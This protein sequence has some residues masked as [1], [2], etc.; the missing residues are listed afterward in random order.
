MKVLVTG[1]NGYIGS[2]L[3]DYLLAKRDEAAPPTYEVR[4]MV[5]PG[6]PL[7]NLSSALGAPNFELVEGD[8]L[9]PATL[10]R[11]VSGV[12][13]VFHLAAL[14][15][16][17][18]PKRKFLEV[19]RDGTRHLLE[20]ATAAGVRRFVYMSTLAVHRRKGH[21]GG[22][23]NTPRDEKKNPYA[24]AKHLAEDLLAEAWKA[25]S[26]ETV[27]VRPGWVI[28]GPRDLLSFGQLARALEDGRMAFINGGNKL[29]SHVYVGNL[30][31]ALEH[32]ASS[33]AEK[34]AGQ[35]F[36]AA[37]GSHTWREFIGAVCTRIGAKVPQRSF[38][39]G[40][41]AP[42]VW[43]MEKVYKLARAKNPPPLTMYRISIPRRDIDFKSDKLLATGFSFPF[44]FEEG[45]DRACAWYAE[46]S[47]KK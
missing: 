5:L 45:M 42:F 6:T 30:V 4:G 29:I 34:V 32:L 8:L 47:R 11:A 28:F 46:H 20:A 43:L 39:Y 27:V 37:D 15:T 12:E 3:V 2:N 13:V 38:P 19:I 24:W 33:P 1:A 21:V 36:V 31:A 35:T 7:D 18:A 40:V 16:D 23:E 14:V 9:S 10:E 44:T 26:L 25:G 22:D 17:W 41:V